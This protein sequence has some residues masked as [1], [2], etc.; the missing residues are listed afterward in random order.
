MAG[1]VGGGPGGIQA[2]HQLTIEHRD[3]VHYDLICSGLRLW[4]IGTRAFGWDDFAVWLKFASPNSQLARAIHGDQWSPE[5]H[6][7]TDIFDV[8][9]AANWQRSGGRG[10][11]PKPARRPGKSQS[12]RLGKPVPFEQVEQYL[13]NRN[14]RAPGG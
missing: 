11:R 2:L 9:A 14:G 1:G 4:Q 6:R 13:I 8:L 10:A 3:A 12:E 7:L 5:M